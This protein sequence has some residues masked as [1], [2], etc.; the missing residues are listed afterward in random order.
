[1]INKTSLKFV[2]GFVV[3]VV[4]AFGSIYYL[5]YYNSPEQKAIRYYKN[6]EKQ[7]AEDT[8][9]GKT[10]EETLQLFIDALKAGDVELASKYFVVEE[11]EKRKEF[12]QKVDN[13]GNLSLFINELSRKNY[14]KRDFNGL[15]ESFIFTFYN[16]KDN[17]SITVDINRLP[18]GIWKITDI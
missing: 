12:L 10:P 7:Y 16:A 5:S 13:A 11:R 14:S 17:T 9:G 15:E 3:I 1:M 18:N 2:G 4:L 8:Y 6:L